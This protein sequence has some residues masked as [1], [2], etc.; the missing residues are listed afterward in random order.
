M[1][2]E[3]NMRIALLVTEI[4]RDAR[5]DQRGV[6]QILDPER[7]RGRMARRARRIADRGDPK[8]VEGVGVAPHARDGI[9]D[10]RRWGRECLR[11]AALDR[12]DEPLRALRLEAWTVEEE[13]HRPFD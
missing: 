8:L 6:G 3:R 5:V 12:V 9:A 2:A 13:F 4:H 1:R 11:V 10:D 7:L